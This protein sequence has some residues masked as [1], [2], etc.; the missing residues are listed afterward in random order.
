MDLQPSINTHVRAEKRV[1]LRHPLSRTLVAHP[2]TY[3][4][5][6]NGFITDGHADCRM[7]SRA[8]RAITTQDVL[9]SFR[10]PKTLQPAR[11]YFTIMRLSG[12][13]RMPYRSFRKYRTMVPIDTFFL[14]CHGGYRFGFSTWQFHFAP[15][16]SNTVA[17]QGNRTE[18]RDCIH[19]TAFEA[20][21][22]CRPGG[23]RFH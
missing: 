4:V 17:K 21:C 5:P 13:Y 19:N 22:L 2:N 7:R 6:P 10:V 11:S 18:Q 3:V 20:F 12:I 23:S 16:S 15:N 1:A 14:V 8:A 9:P